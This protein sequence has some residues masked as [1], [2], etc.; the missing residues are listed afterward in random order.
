MAD[1]VSPSSATMHNP[2]EATTLANAAVAG[3]AV[4]GNG[5]ASPIPTGLT[6][7]FAAYEVGDFYDELF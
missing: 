2:A 3:Q 5:V 6:G 4:S 7:S 1:S